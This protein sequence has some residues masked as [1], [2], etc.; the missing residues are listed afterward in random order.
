MIQGHNAP[1]ET[2]TSS[3]RNLAE[4]P[5]LDDRDFLY[6]EVTQRL[7]GGMHIIFGQSLTAEE[8][9]TFSDVPHPKGVVRGR[10]GASGVH[11]PAAMARIPFQE[12]K[13]SRMSGAAN[14]RACK[15]LGNLAWLQELPGPKGA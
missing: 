14:L 13:R 3:L 9:A 1:T 11:S 12:E 4:V 10:M 7:P 15:V 5:F 6:R 2:A 8:E